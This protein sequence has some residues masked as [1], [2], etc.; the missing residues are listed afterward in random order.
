VIAAPRRWRLAAAATLAAWCALMIAVRRAPS[1]TDD[2]HGWRQADTQAMARNLAFED[3]SPL[4]PRIDW[5]GDGPGHVETELQLYP[6]LIAVALLA[7]GRDSPWPGQLL[8]LAFVALAAAIV[9]AALARRFGPRAGYAGLLAMLSAQG[10]VVISTSIQPDALALLAFTVGFVAFVAYLEAPGRGRLAIWVV[11]TAVAGLVKPTTLEL[12]VAQGVLVLLAHRDALRRP[13]LWIGWALVLAAVALFLLHARSLYTAYGNTFGVLSGGDSKLPSLDRLAS[14]STWV[15]LVRYSIVWGIGVP[16]LI[17]AGA[18]A[19]RRRLHPEEVAL[20]AGA[21]VLSLLALRYTSGPYGTHYHLPH[22][23][24]GAWLVAH[25]VAELTG[26]RPQRPDHRGRIVTAAAVAIAALLTAR[27]LGYVRQLPVEP[28]TTVGHMLATVAPPGTLVVVRARAP[29]RDPDW[30]T[31]NNCED[32]RV[33]FVSR[34]RGW[35]VANDEP[36]AA[37]V[38]AAADRGARFYAHVEQMAP[39]PALAAWLAD[40]GELVATSPVGRVYRLTS[41]RTK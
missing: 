10:A 29:R 20:A 16:G 34:T 5:R 23:V 21:A 38:A 18:L 13:G 11:A 25:A 36:G 9:F 27:A 30:G 22:V 17:A 6:T 12:G 14:P 19:W 41:S 2:Q 40:H 1:I 4:W 8:S 26:E 33:F 32:P 37:P 24:L 3:L 15:G 39:D 28:E 7:I 31:V 35:V